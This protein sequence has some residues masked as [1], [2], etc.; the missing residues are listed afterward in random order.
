MGWRRRRRRRGRKRRGR[1][2][3]RRRGCCR[4]KGIIICLVRGKSKWVP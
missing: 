3:G 1:G 4:M 2:R